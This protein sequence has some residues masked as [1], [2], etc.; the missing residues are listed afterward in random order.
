MRLRGS[1][2]QHRVC[3]PV[4]RLRRARRV[5]WSVSVSGGQGSHQVQAVFSRVQREAVKLCTRRRVG[6]ATAQHAE[7]TAPWAR[8]TLAMPGKK[9][10]RASKRR[11]AAAKRRAAASSASAGA[12]DASGDTTPAAPSATAPTDTAMGANAQ[13][14]DATGKAA[15]PPVHSSTTGASRSK[16]SGSDSDNVKPSPIPAANGAAAAKSEAPSARCC[17]GCGAPNAALR[18]SRCRA[19]VY[20]SK[21]CQVAQWPLHKKTCSA[22]APGSKEEPAIVTESRGA[23]AGAGAGASHRRADHSKGAIITGPFVL[24]DATLEACRARVRRVYVRDYGLHAVRLS[25]AGAVLPLIFYNAPISPYPG[26]RLRGIDT[27]TNPAMPIAEELLADFPWEGLVTA[28]VERG[29]LAHEFNLTA[30]GTRLIGEMGELA[31]A[32]YEAGDRR[33]IGN[34]GTE[35]I[36][37]AAATAGAADVAGTN[38]PIF[39]IGLPR[40]GTS[41]LHLLLSM[42]PKARAPLNWEFGTPSAL[43]GN[44]RRKKRAKA[45]HATNRGGARESEMAPDFPAEDHILFEL[46]GISDLPREAL[47]SDEAAADYH[48]WVA[49]DLDWTAAYRMHKLIV[50]LLEAQEHMLA[51]Q[52]HWVFKDPRTT[53]LI[54]DVVKVYPNAR[55]VMTHRP[56]QDVMASN[57][58]ARNPAGTDKDVMLHAFANVS[59]RALTARAA[60]DVSDMFRGVKTSRFCDVFMADVLA[61]PVEAVTQ[62]Y[63]HFGM[64]M[65]DE[66]IAVL[67]EWERKNTR[68]PVDYSKTELP[69]AMGDVTRAFV[70]SGYVQAFPRTLPGVTI[71]PG[72]IAMIEGGDVV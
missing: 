31:A 39:V 11:A 56:L 23:A 36:T 68:T 13:G 42:D 33:L 44:D 55:F 70:R 41:V 25:Q 54:E 63:S 26:R 20:C 65:T 10:S 45:A 71:L 12:L 17:G 38:P 7:V 1:L 53:A 51:P 67:H 2:S 9:S 62:I 52:S 6:C 19:V 35:S 40:S 24:D 61:D 58:R 49:A 46:L 15:A 32:L 16:A 8:R 37:F 57:L 5:D 28:K 60:I 22:R 50:R 27:Y 64:H 29:C 47:P 18:C 59:K 30:F 21:T 34:V 66:Y 48:R 14:S 3:S 69:Y 4:T 43:R 72:N